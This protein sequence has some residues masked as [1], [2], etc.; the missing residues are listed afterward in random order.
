MKKL[1]LTYFILIQKL[2]V[3]FFTKIKQKQT[4]ALLRRRCAV[5]PTHCCTAD[6]LLHWRT[7]VKPS[8]LL[9]PCF[10]TASSLLRC[11]HRPVAMPCCAAALLCYRRCPVAPD[12]R[13]LYLVFKYVYV[14]ICF[15]T[16][17]LS[18][19]P[20]SAGHKKTVA[21]FL[22]FFSTL[23]QLLVTSVCYV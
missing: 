8:L 9:L 7:V 19:F 3:Y 20:L 17:K 16:G 18:N 11:R 21:I 10:T 23:L 14:Y 12:L 1:S 6:A 2:S 13:E 5:A 15:L 22:F 4:N